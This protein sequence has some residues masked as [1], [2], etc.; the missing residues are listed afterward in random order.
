SSAGAA[1][2]ATV[3]APGPT[4]AI[5]SSAAVGTGL[6]NYAI[7][8]HNASVGLT[9]S[10]KPTTTILASPGSVQYGCQVTLQATVA[11]TSAGGQMISGNVEFFINSV[12]QGTAPV[13][14]TTGVASKTVTVTNAPGGYP[15]GATFSSSNL[16]FAG[17]PAAASTLTVTPAPSQPVADAYYTGPAF[18]WTTGSGSSTA[19]LTLTA[20]LKNALCFGD[21]RTAKA[22]FFVRNG[23]TLTP[24]NGA[25]NLPVGL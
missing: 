11:P 12:S 18:Y 24:I 6:G 5:T 8:Y 13:N 19:T 1:A 22:S 17:S 7:S 25:Q 23:T 21:I 9:V 15:V 20:T 10:T 14:G 3:T 16:N 2:T 4:Y